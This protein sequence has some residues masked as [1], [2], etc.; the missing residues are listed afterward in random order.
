MEIGF[1]GLGIMGSAMAAN[2]LKAGYEVRVWN[3]SPE[4]CRHLVDLGAHSGASP[5]AVAE[6]SDLIIAM[7]AN[8]AAVEAV[9][10][11]SDG[12][13]AGLAPGKGFI[14]MSTVD[15]ETSLES[16]LLAHQAG[17]L[18]LEA[19]VAGSRKPAEDAALTIMAA[20]DR[21][22]Y[23]TALPLFEK[24]GK[25]IL[26]LGATGNAAR[27][28]LANNLVMAGMLTALCEGMALAVK[29]GLDTAQLLEVLD[30]GALS[31]PMFRLKGPQIAAN[32]EFPAAFPLK[33]MQKDL[34]L[35][36]RLAEDSGQPLFATAAVNELF[37]A[38]MA[39][40]LGDADFAAVSRVIR[41]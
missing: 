33:H 1:I 13:I 5:K 4:S 24:M 20:G 8:P 9:R 14:D 18:Y 22:L 27:M 29:S 15:A 31:N 34:R 3:R 32:R 38:A 28:K 25:K 30:S 2:L 41:K 35:A 36:L 23:D 21:Q 26:Y 37:K 6:H 12:I 40:N 17:A 7:M 39:A 16:E 19:P 10:D 11:G